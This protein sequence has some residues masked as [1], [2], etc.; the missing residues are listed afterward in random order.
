MVSS[1]TLTLQHL[2]R[3][4]SRNLGANVVAFLIQ[5][6]AAIE[7]SIKASDIQSLFSTVKYFSFQSNVCGKDDLTFYG[8]FP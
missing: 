1:E 4:I 7:P 3:K 5:R 2:Q 8:L 6:N